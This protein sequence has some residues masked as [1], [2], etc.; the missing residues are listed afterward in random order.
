M[1]T[2][3][4]TRGPERFAAAPVAPVRRSPLTAVGAGLAL[5]LLVVGVPA[6]LLVLTGTPPYPHGLPDR[7]DLTQPL[8]VDAL[9]VV[10]L[11]V[12]WLAW[13][14]FTWCV[15]VEVLSLLRGGGLPRPV[16]LAGRSQALARALV[17]SVLV[18]ATL[19]GS[20]GGATAATLDD[21]PPTGAAV[22]SVVDAGVRSADDAG[23]GA[24]DQHAEDQQRPAQ[25]MEHVPG[26]PSDMT[27]VIGH[28]VV[29]VQPPDGRYHDN[30]WDIAERHLGDGRRWKEIFNLNE[31]RD[32][33][34]GQQLVLGRLIQPGWV[35]IMPGDAVDAPRVHAVPDDAPDPAP[36]HHQHQGGDRVDSTTDAV[37]E[38]STGDLRGG[39]L[40]GGLLAA[41]LTGLIAV[42]R[43]RRRS[44]DPHGAGLD[45]EVALR[46]GADPERVTRLDRALRS[47]SATCR[48]ERIALPQVYA[49]AVSDDAVELR[50]A[51]AAPSAP[52]PWS[53][54]DD[55]R[56]WRLER[57]AELPGDLGHAPY[58]GLVCLGRDDDGA[59]LLVDLEAVAGP[60]CVGGD[61]DVARQVVSALAVQL[62]TAPWS[63]QQ[64]V[65]GHRL[66]PALAAVAGESL[67][68]LDDVDPLLVGWSERAV[69]RPAED[70]LSGRLGRHPGTVPQYLVLGE[71]PDDHV[72]SR[73]HGLTGADARG[74]GVLSTG[75]LPGARWTMRVD[76]AGRLT[77]P[78]L[79][80]EVEA[81][82]LT[83]EMVDSLAELFASVRT[84]EPA[85]T[86]RPRVPDVAHP[87][88]DGHWRAAPVRI[89]VLGPLE[90]TAAGSIDS[91]RL[92]LAIEV[93]TFLA[94][95]P[96]PVH[97]SVVGA[98]VW[99]R[100]V[101]PEVRDAT[102]ARAR[103]WLG[104]DPDGNALLRENA[105]GRLYLARDVAVD[106]HALCTLLERSRN[107]TFREECELLRRALQ[108]V[109][110]PLL[111][112]RPA[113]RYSWLPRTRIERQAEDAVVDAALRVAELTTND[114]PEG[115]A[116]ACR[117]ALR[118][119]PTAQPVWRALLL[120]E[121]RRPDGPG[122]A[123][124]VE[125]LVE[126]LQQ[127][128]A[129]L[130]AETE[131]L[132]VEL[133]PEGPG[134]EATA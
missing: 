81:V 10:L 19:I 32:Q 110:G 76:D 69:H 70:V 122:T 80:L 128:G 64:R 113:G 65:W 22:S 82:R 8:S 126:V 59:D 129:P 90:L 88:D 58:P 7:D 4:P 86:G 28:K 79:D 14:Q 89:G 37:T 134:E 3:P 51:P 5:L 31:G 91:S 104:S 97:A 48:T 132:V 49:V 23:P 103:D 39:L 98:S 12:V 42:E 87:T 130:D 40:A 45:A 54:R 131:A 99:P 111:E 125:E 94:L 102:I 25:R 118:L 73:L 11:A 6:T 105:E 74:V 133:L 9:F 75:A 83:D 109:R 34:D 127:A 50:L 100:G 61:P 15:L 108:L 18:G 53:V 115:A 120:A 33:P 117:A 85:P 30:L 121:H 96:A 66:T 84:D 95:Q 106:W 16:P 119:A 78:L 35:L 107:A 13:L 77:L 46:A 124:V 71:R 116:A 68:L 93:V 57:D 60:L 55:G 20:A 62:A 112:D 1:T 26:V 101:T 47:L 63:D 21:A 29:I 72:I 56:R 43:R 27:D 36:Q 67:T 92:E 24:A 41:A 38:A 114:D 123:R 52:A 2:A 17:G 44:S